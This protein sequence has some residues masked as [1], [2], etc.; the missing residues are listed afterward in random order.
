MKLMA[1]LLAPDSDTLQEWTV[2]PDVCT[3]CQNTVAV[4]PGD[5]VFVAYRG[6]TRDEIRDNF[7]STFDLASASWSKPTTLKDDLWKIPAC[8]VN[9]PAADAR[10]ASVAVAWFTAANGVARVQARTSADAGQTFTAP[11]QVDLGRPIGRL[12]T[13]MLPDHSAVILWLEM[14]S[15]ANAAGLYS[16][17]LFPDGTLSAPQLLTDTTQA[18]ASGFPRAALRPDGRVLVSYTQNGEL[19]QVQVFSFDP[20]PLVRSL[21][22]IAPTRTTRLT[23]FLELCE[24]PL[25]SHH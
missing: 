13:V 12:E 15:E 10:D 6:H 4:L 11:V 16:R 18:R 23:A 1:R 5:R 20:R 9:G 19:N 17:R 2:D 24:A 8:P 3:C 14:K 21:T 22:N 25:A 7:Y